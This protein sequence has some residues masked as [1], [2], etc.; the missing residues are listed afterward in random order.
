V[1]FVYFVV[2]KHYPKIEEKIREKMIRAKTRRAQRNQLAVS[3]WQRA[4]IRTTDYKTA[5]SKKSTPPPGISKFRFAYCI[6]PTAICLLFALAV[7]ARKSLL[8]RFV[9]HFS[10]LLADRL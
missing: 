10:R 1:V 5:S 2:N 6:L 4:V 7:L 9:E 8:K 3:S